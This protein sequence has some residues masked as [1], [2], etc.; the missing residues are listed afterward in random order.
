MGDSTTSSGWLR[1][2]NFHEEDETDTE[3]TAKLIAARQLATM[4][5]D[6]K[7][8]LYSQRLPGDDNDMSDSLSR[9][10][11]LSDENLI[12]LLTLHVPSQIPPNF[13][14]VLLKS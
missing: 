9:D 8:C 13:R 2:S 11:D 14:K 4:I 6:S 12:K 1:K 7:Y 3:Q 10:I 5:V